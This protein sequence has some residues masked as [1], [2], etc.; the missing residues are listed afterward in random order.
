MTDWK[1]RRLVQ[2]GVSLPLLGSLS[3]L[4]GAGLFLGGKKVAVL[5]TSGAS[6]LIAPRRALVIGN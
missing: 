4:T 5:R 2:A 3:S 1:R 6:L